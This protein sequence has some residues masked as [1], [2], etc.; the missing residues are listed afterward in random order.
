PAWS[1]TNDQKRITTPRQALEMGADFMVIGRPITQAKNPVEA[2]LKII[3]ELE[4]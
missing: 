1:E 4:E 2:A 3:A